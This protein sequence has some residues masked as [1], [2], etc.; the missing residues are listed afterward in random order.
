MG[1]CHTLPVFAPRLPAPQAP[2]RTAGCCLKACG[3]RQLEGRTRMDTPLTAVGA[4]AVGER[5]ARG[6]PAS[7]VKLKDPP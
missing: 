5:G 7:S 3:P 6:N 2:L 4:A 1:P